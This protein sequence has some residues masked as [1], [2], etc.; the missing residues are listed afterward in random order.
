MRY[1]DSV[2][3][4]DPGSL[5]GRAIADIVRRGILFQPTL[6]RADVF[7]RSGGK[8]KPSHIDKFSRIENIGTVELQTDAGAECAPYFLVTE[9][10]GMQ[11]LYWQYAAD[12]EDPLQLCHDLAAVDGFRVACCA[13]A[14][15]VFWQ[16][17]DQ[18]AI[19]EARGR[20]HADLPKVW[21]DMFHTHKID[22][23]QNPGRR[24]LVPGLWLQA[25]W[26]MWFGDFVLEMIPRDILCSFQDAETTSVLPDGQVFVQL[27]LDPEACG[28]VEN[29]RRQQSFREHVAM[30]VIADSMKSAR[31]TDPVF[32]LEKGQ[33]PHGGVRRVTK[34]LGVDR[35]P[36]VRSRAGRKLVGEFDSEYKL[37]WQWESEV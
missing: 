36:V 27:F 1:L 3:C 14:E 9:V 22:T 6:I 8:F 2:F 33:F 26:R 15:D 13:D 25:A 35:T 10:S 16:S 18:I 28:T 23:T 24:E 11:C 4:F 12:A 30:D 31:T 29:R 37:L 19:F 21:D 20:A 17:Q 5:D 34:W 32:E 7:M